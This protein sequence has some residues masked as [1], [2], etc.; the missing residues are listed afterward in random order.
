MLIVIAQAVVSNDEGGG[1]T[2]PS[3]RLTQGLFHPADLGTECFLWF[4]Y[5]QMWG[6]VW[7]AIAEEEPVVFQNDLLAPA[8]TLTS[9]TDSV[10]AD[11]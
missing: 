3:T 6:Q 7:P 9:S 1:P 11:D 10:A 5:P 4:L 8:G 2:S